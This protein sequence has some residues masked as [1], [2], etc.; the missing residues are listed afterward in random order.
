MEGSQERRGQPTQGGRRA[1]TVDGRRQPRGWSI[2]RRP[3]ASY[4]TVLRSRRSSA[5]PAHWVR[6]GR[7]PSSAGA[8]P[9]RGGSDVSAEQRASLFGISPFPLRP[10]SADV[11]THAATIR[12]LTNAG[13]IV[14]KGHRA[15]AGAGLVRPRACFIVRRRMMFESVSKSKPGGSGGKV[16]VAVVCS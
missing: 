7:R 3:A 15:V 11:R 2:H 14:S 5:S 8:V 6:P 1:T 12:Y 4:R 16:T 13:Q 9:D 10:G